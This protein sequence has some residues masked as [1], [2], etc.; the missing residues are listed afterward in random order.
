[1]F[2]VP[3]AEPTNVVELDVERINNPVQTDDGSTCHFIDT[4]KIEVHT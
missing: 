1:M 2:I 4:Q 3:C